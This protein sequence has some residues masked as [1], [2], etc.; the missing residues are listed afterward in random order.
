MYTCYIILYTGF[1]TPLNFHEFHE[2]FWIIEIKFMKCYSYIEISG[3]NVW[4]CEILNTNIQFIKNLGKY[5]SM[6]ITLYTVSL[7]CVYTYTLLYSYNDSKKFRYCIQYF[8]YV[9]YIAII[10]VQLP[11]FQYEGGVRLVNGVLQ[12]TTKFHKLDQPASYIFKQMNKINFH[13]TSILC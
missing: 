3:N 2:L 9:M 8:V 7:V 1:F 4:I 11:A 13:S 10:I 12:Y 6:K 5:T